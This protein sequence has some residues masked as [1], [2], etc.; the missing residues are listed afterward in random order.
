MRFSLCGMVIAAAA[1]GL[2]GEALASPA[3]TTSTSALQIDVQPG[4][5]PWTR[6]DMTDSCE[7]V[8]FAVM[9]DRAGGP[10]PG[11]FE[12]GVAK[13]NLLQPQFVVNVG[14]LI[15]GYNRNK[16]QIDAWWAELRAITGQLQ[17]PFFY[18]PGNHD[19]TNP[20]EVEEWHQKF[21]RTYYHFVFHDV[22]F[23]CANTEDPHS[24]ISPEQI[25]YFR[26]V[27][28]KNPKPR[29]TFVFLHQP[30]WTYPPPDDL[31]TSLTLKGMT[32]EAARQQA[33]EQNL[34]DV[35]WTPFEKLLEGRH[36]TVFAGHTHRYYMHRRNGHDYIVLATTGGGS[37]TRGPA[38][39]AFDQIAWVTLK[40]DKPEIANLLL[41]GIYARDLRNSDTGPVVGSVLQQSVQASP[42]IAGP[43]RVSSA[44]QQ[45]LFSNPTS[46]SLILH[47]AFEAHPQFLTNPV[48]FDLTLA[49]GQRALRDYSI[50]SFG[51]IDLDRVTTPI[52][53]KWTT[54]VTVPGHPKLKIEER[55]AIPFDPKH[56]LARANTRIHVDGRLND[57]PQ[58][59]ILCSEPRQMDQPRP[60]WIGPDDCRFRFGAAYDDRYLYVAA[61]VTDDHVTTGTVHDAVTL[62]VDPA[63]EKGS[64]VTLESSDSD[65]KSAQREL[66]SRM[67]SLT[68]D[69]SSTEPQHTRNGMQIAW[70]EKPGGYTAEFAIPINELKRAQGSKW[71]S[72]RLNLK[73]QDVDNPRES[74]GLWW[75][76]DWLG[77]AAYKDEGLFLRR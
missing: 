30:M 2:C 51:P 7:E 77:R 60:W 70:R 66:E 64:T 57:W 5:N 29:W 9:A 62:L 55:P 44:K 67:L 73:V 25:A 74:S 49:P 34:S 46:S 42:I 27:L 20:V 22:L 47:A 26:D 32:K 52:I 4:G 33:I 11:V 8:Q 14:D 35:G 59:P 18:V 24:H 13:L 58:L 40:K 31:V 28:E 19:L 16:K 45:I 12:D 23:L 41:D 1:L 76:P 54:D 15:P 6:L 17:M 38:Y 65:R 53:L 10:R 61:D 39:G 72:V 68:A 48:A 37:N 63:G 50:R 69:L 21:G 56:S 3:A 43:G 71:G 36:Y 75:R